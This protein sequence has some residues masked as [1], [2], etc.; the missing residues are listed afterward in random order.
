MYV[1]CIYVHIIYTHVPCVYRYYILV[2]K[3]L[4]KC[5]FG[6]F[7]GNDASQ[8]FAGATEMG[9]EELLELQRRNE[10]R[11]NEDCICVPLEDVLRGPGHVA[12]KLIKDI[13]DNPTAI[14]NSMRSKFSSSLCLFGPWSKPGGNSLRPGKVQAQRWTPCA[15]CRMI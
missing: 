2:L 8:A 13:K 4:P 12:W 9:L 3:R 6:G 14:L 5:A 7:S 10:E 15:S 11:Q 1:A